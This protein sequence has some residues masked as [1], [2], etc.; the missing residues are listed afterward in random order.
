VPSVWA[1][2]AFA[3]RQVH[4][5]PRVVA[6][7]AGAVCTDT[8]HRLRTRPGVDPAGLGEAA[9]H[10]LTW[11]FAEVLGRSYGGGVLE[12][13]PSE[14]EALPIVPPDGGGL[15]R[16]EVDDLRQIWEVLSTRRRPR[17]GPAPGR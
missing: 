1:P 10:P 12:L 3:L 4:A 8:I 16:A 9:N 11:A 2:D 7:P 17:R 13:E 15:T 6:N 14:A 5:A